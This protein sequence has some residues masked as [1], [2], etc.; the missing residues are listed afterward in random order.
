MESQCPNV[1][2]RDCSMLFSSSHAKLEE[3][4]VWSGI[5]KTN[6][7][8]WGWA[9]ATVQWIVGLLPRDK[10]MG[11]SVLMPTDGPDWAGCTVTVEPVF[12][13]FVP[14]CYPVPPLNA[15]N[16]WHKSTIHK[17]IMDTHYTV[18]GG[19]HLKNNKFSFRPHTCH[20]HANYLRFDTNL[21][22]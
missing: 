17:L 22:K 21:L 1:K 4:T 6:V 7:I 9:T 11:D 13:H 16:G 20:S 2:D 15:R 18:D 19:F 3:E 12:T 5:E 10:Q 8:K 14:N